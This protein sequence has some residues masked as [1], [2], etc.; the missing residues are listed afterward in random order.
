MKT[1]G[2][3]EPIDVKLPAAVAAQPLREQVIS[4]LRKAIME[5]QLKPGQRLV[6]RELIEALGVSR[7]TVREALRELASEGLVTVVPQRGAMVSAPTE[8]EALDFYDVRAS[9]EAL[10]V[11]RF[12]DRASAS[13]VMRFEAAVELFA[14]LADAEASINEMLAAKD[15]MFEVLLQG[16]GSQALRQIIEGIQIRVRILRAT[17]M[18]G[19]DRVSDSVEELRAVARAIAAHDGVLAA[20]LYAEHIRAAAKSA[21]SQLQ[22]QRAQ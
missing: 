15:V 8:E 3:D 10:I 6:E 1:A 7:T 16:A 9:L 11:E 20:E 12:V 22:G 21:M 19:P 5:F 17:S 14:E 13:Q 2:H 18:S 4:A